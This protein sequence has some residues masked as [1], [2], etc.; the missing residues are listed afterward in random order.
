MSRDSYHH[1]QNPPGSSPPQ[2]AG[3][4]RPRPPDDTPP[5]SPER[6]GHPAVLKSPHTRRTLEK[7]RTGTPLDPIEYSTPAPLT[8]IPVAHAE[9]RHGE[10]ASPVLRF[11]ET[12]EYLL[13]VEIGDLIDHARNLVHELQEFHTDPVHAL[14]GRARAL[15]ASLTPEVDHTPAQSPS[16]PYP[17]R[18]ALGTTLGNS[19]YESQYTAEGICAPSWRELRHSPHR[20]ILR[21]T[22][23]PPAINQRAPVTAL[24]SILDDSTLER[25]SPS[26]IQ[27]VNWTSSGNLVIHTRAPYTAS[28]LAV[29][30]GEAVI[31]IVRRECGQFLGSAVLE[32]DSPWIPVVVHGVPAQPLVESLKFEQEDFWVRREKQ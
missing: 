1:H 7:S 28:Q 17:S 19:A 6:P 8:P 13:A 14:L 2:T 25:Y 22:D 11:W 32:L 15:Y 23:S 21:W 29:I 24:A 18:P 12:P 16:P 5:S 9:V 27:G 10:P 20:L 30:H 3:L 31:E 4:V 26:H